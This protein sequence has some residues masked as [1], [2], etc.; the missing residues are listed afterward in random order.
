MNQAFV[1]LHA[2]LADPHPGLATWTSALQQTLKDCLWVVP[3]EWLEDELVQRELMG[4]DNGH[5]HA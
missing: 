5:G 3:T 4:D 1:R 2:L